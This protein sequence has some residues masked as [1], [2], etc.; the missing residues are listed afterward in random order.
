MNAL[1][2]AIAL[3]LAAPV[4][5]PVPVATPD[6]AADPAG[7]LP[8]VEVV[9]QRAEQGT[10]AG[11]AARLDAME[12]RSSR[13]LT[14]NEA[15]RKVPGVVVR[16][17]EG[18]GL[19]PNIGVRGLNP[20]RS[21]KVL[22]LEDGIPAAYAPYGD[23][24]SYYHAP[25]DRYAEIEVLKGVGMLRFG[26]QTIG[27]IVNYLTPEPPQDFGGRASL[28]GGNLGYANA[29]VSVGGMGFLFDAYRKQG[30]GAR[31]NQRLRQADLN[32][33]SVVE[34]G[35]HALTFRATRLEEDSQVTYSG[36]TEAEYRNF[37]ARYNPFRNDFFDIT[38][39]GGSV[40]H[41]WAPSE[42]V[43][44]TTSAYGFVFKRD[45]WRQSSSTTDSQC[46][47]AF[48]SARLAGQSVNV[49]ACNSAQ[50]R[51]RN[52]YTVG[53][54]PRLL[55]TP[56]AL[57]E[58]GRLEFGVRAHRETQERRQVNA[59]SPLGRV[60]TLAED[61]RRVVQARAGFVEAVVDLGSVSLIPALRHERIEAERLNK[62]NGRGG[63]L[64]E[65]AW[66]PGLG[67]VWEIDANHRLYGG[68]HR[69]FAPPRVED[70]ID[71]NGVAVDVDAEKS[72]NVE[73][74]LRGRFGM[75]SYDLTGFDVDFSNQVAVGSIAGGAT[76]LAQGETRYRGMELALRH[77][78]LDA[79]FARPYA[80]A[81]LTWLP[82]ADQDS[83]LIAVSNGQIVGNSG[84]GKRLP[85]APEFGA[86]L[87][88][89]AYVADFDLSV[90]AVY[91]GE[92]FTDFANTLLP[93]AN[94]Q[95]GRIGGTTL[96]NLALNWQPADQRFGVFLAVK[97]AFDRQYIADRTRGI[98]PGMGRQILAGVE[99][100]Y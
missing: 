60:G 15:L 25:I 30:D 17:E 67:A 70:L 96:A 9:G 44:L 16:D 84:A 91:V 24:A 33:K 36:L 51:L 7:S 73:L 81:A 22:L 29:H 82:V 79:G 69:G 26:P 94:G 100:D 19:R 64:T 35:A 49:D 28:A 54:E 38:R 85:Y 45:W 43:K 1:S 52:Y 86:T 80:S 57:G 14:I 20:T 90:E 59:T 99:L 46:G 83:P 5:T 93:T 11:S 68:I 98:L 18:F 95:A 37:G 75:L 77:E 92:Q 88:L 58:S 55:L 72:R 63:E 66:I 53:L 41:A 74:G 47:S 21:T 97:N 23:N 71:N 65:S 89:G 12:L 13:A 40:T 31:D 78:G 50:G 48:T 8:A 3:A 10:L 34:L 6:P 39:Q 27:G 56:A 76:P 42:G 4:P 32:L 2:L 62:L 61:N 87:R